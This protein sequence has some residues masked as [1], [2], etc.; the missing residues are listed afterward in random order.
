MKRVVIKIGTNILTTSDRKLDL[1]NLRNLV[2]Q[3]GH[4]IRN[5]QCE[6]IIVTSGSITCG[7]EVLSL[8][9]ETIQQKQAS[10][11][12]GQFLLM[13]E[14]ATFFSQF[15]IQVGQILLTR[16]AIENE[17]RRLNVQNTIQTLLSLGIVP[18]INENDSVST[19]EIQFGDND[20]LS[21]RVAV[22]AKADLLVILTDTEGLFTKNPKIDPNA[23]LIEKVTE[24]D[25]DVIS[26]A[27]SATS[28]RSKGGM[29]TKVLA[30]QFATE[31][32]I[33][34]R[35]A[36]GRKPNVISD[37]L[38]GKPVGTQFLGKETLT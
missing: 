4:L 7:S 8:H 37:I 5:K 1:N 34:T 17:D 23:T 26:R 21:S 31:N 28:D 32:G 15:G 6:C 38:D 9:P 11:S 22:L 10:A 25:E 16:D 29:L 20:N 30:A 36:F 35:I 13:R 19:E 27:D 14:Y 33:E 12:V 24:V 2:C 3:I 18:I